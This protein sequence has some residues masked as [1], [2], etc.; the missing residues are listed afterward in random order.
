MHIEFKALNKGSLVIVPVYRLEY[1]SQV[2]C[3]EKE[4]WKQKSRLLSSASVR[5]MPH[6]PK[7]NCTMKLRVE[8]TTKTKVS[9]L[10]CK[11][12][13]LVVTILLFVV[14]T[15]CFLALWLTS[16]S[17]DHECF[18][19]KINAYKYTKNDFLTRVGTITDR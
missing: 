10:P 9:C 11:W 12:L 3:N 4:K 8:D 17:L 1:G 5:A 16:V 13:T 14:C 19:Q 2:G 15:L 6:Q 18:P 7:S